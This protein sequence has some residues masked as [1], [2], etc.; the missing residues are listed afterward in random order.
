MPVKRECA[1]MDCPVE[2]ALDLIGGRWKTMILALL[3]ERQPMR[4]N[5]LRRKLRGVTHRVL[6]A[7][8]RDLEQTGLVNRT[9]YA[10][11][12]PRAEYAP[13][14]LAR[15]L[16]PLLD[17]LRRWGVEYALSARKAGAADPGTT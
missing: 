16:R 11:V 6:T 8:L 15:T 12:P 4:F 5:E 17:E 7:Q 2:A 10:Q 14:E 1:Y 9:V 3:L 13:T